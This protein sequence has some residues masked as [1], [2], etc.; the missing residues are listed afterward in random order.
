MRIR[1]VS[2]VAAIGLASVLA[3]CDVTPTD[4][5]SF[6]Y[7]AIVADVSRSIDATFAETPFVNGSVAV[8][9]TE[10]GRLRTYRLVPCQ[11]GTA[12]C[13]GL[14][15]RAAVQPQ[16]TRDHT[17]VSGLYGDRTFFLRPGGG[18]TMRRGGVDFPLAWNSHV[19]GVPRSNLSSP[20]AAGPFPR[21]NY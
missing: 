7:D 12:I 17:I 21:V 19:N 20:Y 10:N 16:V 13:S 11:N 18:G 8:V 15:H 4:S 6:T 3:G 2:F 14:H 1:S 5:A 9:T